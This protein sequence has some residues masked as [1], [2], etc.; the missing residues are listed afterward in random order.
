LSIAKEL[1]K[2]Q[3][4]QTEEEL[5]S[6]YLA[7]KAEWDERIGSA[8]VQAYNWR[9]CA[10]GAILL[11]ILLGVGLIYQSSKTTVI[12]YVVRVNSD[13]IA[14]SVGTP[15]QMNYVPKEVEIKYF[16]TQFVQKIRALSIDPVVSKHN[17]VSAYAFLTQTAAQKMNNYIKEDNPITKLGKITTQVEINVIVPISKDTYQI[18]W[19]EKVFDKDGGSVETYK[20]TGI[21]SII[22]SPP[23]D[24]K[25][26]LSNP[27]GL[28]IKDFSYNK[29]I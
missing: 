20:M 6:P 17:W 3:K 23:T 19:Q 18:R 29:E 21:F 11:N 9:I 15:E 28:Y 5:I 26:L 25:E 8:R 4:Y 16:L 22:V 27:L 2:L 10:L 12:P 7:A 24:Q 1:S 13:G 14:Q